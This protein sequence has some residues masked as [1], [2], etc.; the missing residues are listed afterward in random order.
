MTARSKTYPR[1]SSTPKPPTSA[2]WNLSSDAQTI[3][4]CV[5]HA[6]SAKG[7]DPIT[8]IVGYL[9]SGDPTYITS[10]GNA[11]ALICSI[12]RDELIEELVRMYVSSIEKE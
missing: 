5:Y 6:L 4:L 7:Y 1:S 8:Q 9:I 3:L 10:Y 2:R 11:R 12:E